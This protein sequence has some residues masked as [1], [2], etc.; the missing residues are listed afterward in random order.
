MRSF[1][2]YIAL[3]LR[4]EKDMLA[5]SGCTY[6]LSQTESEE[7]A[8]IRQGLRVY[9]HCLCFYFDSNRCYQLLKLILLLY[10]QRKH[11][12]LEGERH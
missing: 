5:F 10:L 3:H 2:P 4:Y 9:L 7:L 12:L 1:G 6:G 8:V 11:N